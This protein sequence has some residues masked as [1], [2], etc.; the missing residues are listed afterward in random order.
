MKFFLV[1]LI[2]WFVIFKLLR[3]KFIVYKGPSSGRF[4]GNSKKEGSITLN[5]SDVKAKGIKPSD[6]GEYVDYEEVK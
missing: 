4:Q 2:I 6:N 1:S 3:F 5:K